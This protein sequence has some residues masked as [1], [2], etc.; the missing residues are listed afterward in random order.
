MCVPHILFLV[1]MCVVQSFHHR[2][3]NH[4]KVN[5]GTT[6]TSMMTVYKLLTATTWITWIIA[7]IVVLWMISNLTL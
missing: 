4:R 7:F 2:K 3:R 6:F 1:L 5:I